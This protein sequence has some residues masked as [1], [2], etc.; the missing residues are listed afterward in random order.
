MGFGISFSRLPYIYLPRRLARSSAKSGF[1]SSCP[2][3]PQGSG[4]R[5]RVMRMK[6]QRG[7]VVRRVHPCGSEEGSYLKLIDLCTSAKS[8]FQS[9]ISAVSTPASGI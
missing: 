5:D 9:R 4:F 6:T 7:G 3:L 2:P 1:Q 8:G